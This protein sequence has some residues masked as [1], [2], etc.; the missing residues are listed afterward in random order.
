MR[1]FSIFLGLIFSI[2]QAEAL[3]ATGNA[4][5]FIQKF[6]S[7][8]EETPMNFGRVYASSSPGDVRSLQLES[9]LQ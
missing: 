3:T 1:Y 7:I 5:V 4:S 2:S 9:D 6:I 8:S